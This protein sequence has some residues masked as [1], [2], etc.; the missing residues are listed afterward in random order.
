LGMLTLL[1]R[2]ATLEARGPQNVSDHGGMMHEPALPPDIVLR[3][4]PAFCGRD[5][6][7]RVRGDRIVSAVLL[8]DPAP[9]PEGRSIPAQDGPQTPTRGRPQVLSLLKRV[10]TPEARVTQDAS[11]SSRPP[12]TA[13]PVQKRPRRRRAAEGRQPGATPGHPGPPQVRLEP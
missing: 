7:T 4:C 12:S 10:A 6:R 5:R 13:S 11:N 8:L 9:L 3:P 1:K 2:L